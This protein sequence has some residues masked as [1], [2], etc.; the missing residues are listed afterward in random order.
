LSAG[1]GNPYGVSNYDL[2]N[3][4]DDNGRP[5]H[6][7]SALG[8]VPIISYQGGLYFE[9]INNVSVHD[10]DGDVDFDG[11]V[12]IEDYNEFIASFGDRGIGLAADLDGDYDVDLDDY[13]VLQDSFAGA[14]APP[15][16]PGGVVP[17]P[18]GICLLGLCSMVMIAR[19][20][21]KS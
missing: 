20:R 8:G 9:M 17:E 7:D 6:W 14:T 1:L 21:R 10:V 16:A 18:A 19:R 15:A 12:D 2:V 5:A 13:A 4:W 11:D 3:Y